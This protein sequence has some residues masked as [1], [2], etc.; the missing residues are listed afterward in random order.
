MKRFCLVFV[1]SLIL[2]TWILTVF[3]FG[4]VPPPELI[5]AREV[6]TGL[7]DAERN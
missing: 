1:A 2:I 4:Y 3:D 7:Y 6:K 5:R